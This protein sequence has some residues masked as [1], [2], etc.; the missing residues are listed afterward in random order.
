V[1]GTVL[2]CA[3]HTCEEICHSGKC[4]PC[5][6]SGERTC[7]CGKA[8][9]NLPCTEDIPT[10]GD[11][12]E[13]ELECKIHMCSE[14]CHTGPCGQCRQLCMKKC[15]CGQRSKE[16][17]CY[18]EYLCETKCTRMKDCG[19][20]QCRR[21]CCDKNC[22]S[23]EQ[24]CGKTL[25]C[26]NHKC[27]SRCHTGPCYPCPL[28]VPVTCNCGATKVI[29][30]CGRDKVTRP[31]RCKLPCKIPPDCHHP[32]RIEHRCHFNRCPPCRQVCG[33]NHEKCSHTCPA[34]CHSAVLTKVQQG[35]TKFPWEARPEV[36]LEQKNF[37]CPP[38]LVPVPVTCLGEHETVNIP[39]WTARVQSCGRECKRLLPCGNHT[40][41]LECHK[42]TQAI[43][44]DQA[45]TNCSQCE[46]PCEKARAK[47]CSHPCVLACH[48]DECPSCKQMIRMR[49]HCQLVVQYVE[50]YKWTRAGQREKDHL[51]ACPSQCPK[52]L[53][54][55]H[56][57]TAICHPG[58]CPGAETCTK[59]MTVKCPCKFIK[60][61]FPCH[62]VIKKKIVL[63][64]DEVC[65]MTREKQRQSKDDKDK[66]K[67]EED[68]KRQQEELEEFERK[69]KK[70][71]RKPRKQRV[72]EEEPSFIQ[73]FWKVGLS[74]LVL[75]VAIITYL[76]IYAM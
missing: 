3:S 47:G 2:Q 41:S 76:I 25:G 49:C 55:G 10:C 37:E 74:I 57:C 72:V 53:K 19:K 17:P 21:K 60:K 71:K 6:R 13:K 18:K 63:Q 54:C 26:R 61:E 31:P 52:M 22:P 12:C 56:Q 30:P 38:C 8:K 16:I 20:H 23:C 36:K 5:P 24:E 69:L 51:K 48:P 62:E 43:S 70:P 46:E 40:C 42:V 27:S 64:C 34:I 67:Q 59:K 39:C 35:K 28:T 73:R 29:V 15:R 11:T 58:S 32:T 66:Q 45:G 14:R 65:K 75:L 68:L 1:C 33:K 4:G 50:C 9:A 44:S 7:P